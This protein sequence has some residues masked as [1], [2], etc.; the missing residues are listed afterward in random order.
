M[1]SL[2]GT[3]GSYASVPHSRCPSYRSQR[4]TFPEE[5][6]TYGTARAIDAPIRH[7]VHNI[8]RHICVSAVLPRLEIR[9]FLNLVAI[10]G[11]G[12]LENLLVVFHFLHFWQCP[13]SSENIRWGSLQ[14]IMDPTYRQS[15]IPQCLYDNVCGKCG[16]FVC[17]SCLHHSPCIRWF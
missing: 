1:L 5:S 12:S 14:G 15:S 17:D 7:K 4:E 8:R 13:I 10:V 6:Y 16:Y 3:V 9:L 2:Q 11:C